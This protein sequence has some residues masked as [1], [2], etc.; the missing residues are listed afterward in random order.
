MA[1]PFKPGL[2]SANHLVTG[3]VIYLSA[4]DRW[5]D[6]PE[7][8]ELITDP[9][10]AQAR[11]AWAEAQADI[12]VGPY[13]APAEAGPSGP[14][15]AHFRETFRAQGPSQAARVSWGQLHA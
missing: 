14:R 8:A 13:L 1:K 12:A 6:R 9:D 10:R 5:V 3:A 4:D 11:L 15:P 2:V 7:R